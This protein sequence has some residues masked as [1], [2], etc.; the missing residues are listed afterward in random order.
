MVNEALVTGQNSPVALRMPQRTFLDADFA[1]HFDALTSRILRRD[2]LAL[3]ILRL[4]S[5]NQ[6]ERSRGASWHRVFV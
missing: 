1:D 5:E 6:V 4:L 2:A 3:R